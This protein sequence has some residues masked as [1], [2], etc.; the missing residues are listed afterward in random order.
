MALGYGF[1]RDRGRSGNYRVL[2]QFKRAI[3]SQMR[4]M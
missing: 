1:V 2:E 3:Y 4:A